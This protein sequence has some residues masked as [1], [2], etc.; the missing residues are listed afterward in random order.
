MRAIENL[1]IVWND[2][3]RFSSEEQMWSAFNEKYG[4]VAGPDGDTPLGVEVKNS[5]VSFSGESLALAK[6]AASSSPE[7]CSLASQSRIRV[8]GRADRLRR[9]VVQ[10]TKRACQYDG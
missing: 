3:G 8:P 1:W 4:T 5:K 10:K 7:F 2:T 6:V 9:S